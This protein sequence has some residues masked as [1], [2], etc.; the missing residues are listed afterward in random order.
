MRIGILTGGGDTA[1]LNAIIYGAAAQAEEDKNKLV[2]FIE[3]WKGVLNSDYIELSKITIDPNVAGTFI[4]TSR[5]NLEEDKDIAK[6]VDNLESTVNALIAIGGDDTLT[7]GKKLKDRLN[8]PVCFITKTIDNDVGINAA[9]GEVDYRRIVNYFTSGFAT[10]ATKS[11]NYANELRSTSRSH[12]RIMFLETMGRS[13]GWLAL[14]TYRANPDFIL[15]PETGLDFR[16]FKEKLAKRYKNK[17]YAIV[18]VAEG[19]RYEGSDKPISRDDSVV[20]VFGHERLGGVAQILA[21]RIKQELGIDN[22]NYNNPKHLYRCGISDNPEEE[23]R[24][25]LLDKKTG[26][27]LG[28]EAAKAVNKRNTGIVAVLQRHGNNIMAETKPIDDVLLTDKNGK[29]I[30]RNLDLRF[31]DSKNYCITDLG[32]EYFRVIK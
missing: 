26:I 20:D 5:T 19:V 17:G 31:Y 2:G 24:P 14:S 18:V 7:V 8:I 16:H 21:E 30:P 13:P 3:G 10:A 23:S 22:S 1:S 32:K 29:I 4:L 28:Q 6:A 9:D 12:R 11:A 27:Y 25:T 15:V